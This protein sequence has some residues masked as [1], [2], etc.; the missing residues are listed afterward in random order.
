MAS[1]VQGAIGSFIIFN[2]VLGR[3]VLLVQ[4][5]DSKGFPASRTTSYPSDKA[6]NHYLENYI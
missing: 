3:T 5:G 4:R 6:K 2:G 1:S